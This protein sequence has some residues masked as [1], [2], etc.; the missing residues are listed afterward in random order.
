MP[1]EV[2]EK[3][4]NHRLR[5]LIA[6][7]GEGAVACDEQGHVLLMTERAEE[8]LGVPRAQVAGK[9][10]DALGA[11]DVV[12]EMRAAIAAGAAGPAERFVSLRLGGR[13]IGCR[14][15]RFEA[16]GEAGWVLTLRDDT[17]LFEQQERSEAILAGAIDGLVVFSPDNR[18]TYINPSACELTGLEAADVVGTRT[19]M[20]A[21]L[22][23]EAADVS[24]AEPCWEMTGCERT[25]CPEYDSSDLRCWLVTGTL[26]DDGT[27]VSFKDKITTCE[28]CDVYRRNGRVLEE[29]GLEATREFTVSDP[30]H[31]VMKSRTNPVFGSGGDYL[32]CVVSLRDVTAERETDRMKNEFVSTVSHELRTPLT[33]IKGYV[34]LILDGEAG[35][36]TDVQREFLTIVQQNND[37]LVE[38]INDLLDISRIESGRIHLTI[39]PLDVAELIAGAVGTFQ[40]A[41]DQTDLE[42]GV[43][44]PKG[45]PKAVGDR[46]RV[47]QVLI[48]L[49]S[50]AI[51]YSPGGGT[52]TLGVERS[53]KELVVS[54]ADTGIGIPREDQEKIF[55]KFYRVDS[56]LTRQISGTGLGLPICKTIINLLGGRIWV[57]S[58][59]G[60]GSKFSFTLPVAPKKMT[61]SSVLAVSGVTPGAPG[62]AGAA[63]GKVLVVDRDVQVANLIEIYLAKKGYEV[64]KAHSAGEAMSQAITQQ[65]QAIT[66]DVMLGDEDGFELLQQLKDEPRTADIPVVVLSVVCDEGKSWRLGAASYL[67]KPIEPDRLIKVIDHLVEGKVEQRRVL[68]VDDDRKMV[69]ALA[70]T[71]TARGFAVD[72]A[73]DGVEAM[74]AIASRSPDLI[75]LDLRMPRMD[76]Y[77]VIERVKKSDATKRIPIVVMTRYRLKRDRIDLL[78]MT[79]GQLAKPFKIEQLASRVEDMLTRERER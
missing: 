35:E 39:Q 67:E 4:R 10:F 12:A 13:V 58:K 26:A 8:F 30:A 2:H 32:G 78:E 74:E 52:I 34:D 54:V 25:D 9:T 43:D 77:Q 76:G 44:L 37:R 64:V 6:S 47:G 50:N 22:R 73:Y 41:V 51:K 33:S 21:L 36:I 62:G 59:V 49:V 29:G 46:D 19:T 60:K 20:S 66:L 28:T 61:A 14:I 42:L 55:T 65:P 48:N 11:P 15:A 16:P 45:L 31:R 27:P 40:A 56:S 75:L 3:R 63:G 68:V 1:D 5:A 53:G 71:L 18:V 79:A 69:D 57:E 23:L 38:L 17:E 70:E 24:E 72:R 7:A